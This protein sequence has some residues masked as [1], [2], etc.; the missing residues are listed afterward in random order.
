MERESEKERDWRRRR[1]RLLSRRQ[2]SERLTV[3]GATEQ[4]SLP[5]FAAP[6]S[7]ACTAARS[8][9]SRSPTTRA[10]R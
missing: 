7:C 10:T 4:T 5:V 8:A 2:E 1:K 9:G 6:A 3:L